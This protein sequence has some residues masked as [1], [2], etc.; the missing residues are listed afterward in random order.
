MTSGDLVFIGDVHLD[1]DDAHLEAFLDLL[2]TLGS[3]THRLVLMGDLFN[4]WIAQPEL[5]QPH[6]TAVLDAFR[7]LRERGVVLRYLEG[8]RDYRVAAYAGDALDDVSGGTIEER[9]GGLRVLAT[10]G[11]LANP[12]DRQYRRWRRFSSSS[13]HFRRRHRSHRR[14]CP[15]WL[16]AR[17]TRGSSRPRKL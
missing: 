7:R 17:R 1:R 10:H 9:F 3:T 8:N 4:L 5:E 12:G 2:R 11:D 14:R 13:R 6:Q 15:R 16:Q